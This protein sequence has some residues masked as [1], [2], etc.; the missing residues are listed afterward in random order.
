MSETVLERVQ[1]EAEELG[2]KM[3]KLRNF[4]NSDNFTSVS[5][6]QQHLLYRQYE[7][8]REYAKCLRFRIE[9]FEA[10][11]VVV[12]DESE[13]M[14]DVLGDSV[15]LDESGL[16]GRLV[17]RLKKGGFETVGQLR[18]AYIAALAS[19][20]DLESLPGIGEGSVPEIEA[21]ILNDRT[22]EAYVEASK[23]LDSIDE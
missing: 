23:A 13:S 19:G 9:D 1:K 18:E 4:L 3:A 11:G 17:G 16:D 14:A 2:E 22:P 20:D 15:S 8:M 7:A 10:A 6:S 5:A 12:S 21:K